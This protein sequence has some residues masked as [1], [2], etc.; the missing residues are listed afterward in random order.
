MSGFGY[1]VLGFGS[2]GVAPPEVDDQFNRVTFL[3]RFDG[4]NNGVNIAFDDGSASNH[5]MTAHG[6][7]TQ[8]SFG[9]FARPDGEWGITYDNGYV[10]FPDSADWTL[11]TT[12]TLEA[13]INPSRLLNYN[14]I[15]NHASWYFSVRANGAL[16]IHGTGGNGE[17]A[18]GVVALDTWSHVA[19]SVS[20]GTGT[21]YVNGI[22]KG[23]TS[24]NNIGDGSGAFYVGKQGP[25]YWPFY[26]TQSNYRVVKGTAVYTG[27]FTPPTAP[28]TAIT[29]T[30]LLTGQSNRFVDNST[31]AHVATSSST[32]EFNRPKTTAFGPFLTDAAYNP[33]VNG[34]S[35]YNGGYGNGAN[36]L[37]TADSADFNIGNGNHT[38]ECWCY[39]ELIFPSGQKSLLG[40]YSNVYDTNNAANSYTLSVI[41]GVVKYYIRGRINAGVIIDLVA[42]GVALTPGMW[43]HIAVVRNGNAFIIYTNGVAGNTNT[44]GITAEDG[45]GQF[46]IGGLTNGTNPTD[47]SATSW[48]GWIADARLVVGTAV[49]TSN[50]TPPTAPLTAITNTKLLLNMAD[51]QIID[52]AAQNNM[53]LYGGAKLSTGQVKFGDTSAYFDGTAYAQASKPLLGPYPENFTLEFWYYGLSKNNPEAGYVQQL[54]A[55]YVSSGGAVGP[56]GLNYIAAGTPGVEL[57][58]QGSTT[59]TMRASAPQNEWVHVALTRSINNFVIYIN[60]TSGAT[61]TSA[62]TIY[63]TNTTIGGSAALTSGGY[64]FYGYMSNLRLTKA[65]RYTGNFT[66]PDEPFPIQGQI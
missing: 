47:K 63:G 33:A 18:A 42:T 51:G 49:Y 27:N 48:S 34:A 9:P 62:N 29:N 30:V 64:D 13:F 37:S 31:S 12:F 22:S 52:N 58:L 39:A 65:L 5:T 59:L 66:V 38:L 8:G 60:G 45:T 20:S 19:F 53:S 24:S 41:N 35:F 32:D 25:D 61:G 16:H 56:M 10:S 43:N 40:H 4:A 11:G 2:G 54:V 14:N 23:T 55:Q 6:I 50:F 15:M 36:F 3:S 26:G 7:T 17:T 28:L 44:I 57:Y 1:D 21:F 46:E